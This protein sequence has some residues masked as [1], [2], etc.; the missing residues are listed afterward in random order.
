M[1]HQNLQGILEDIRAR[2]EAF[3]CFHSNRR[4][5]IRSIERHRCKCRCH[6]VIG[7][8]SSVASSYL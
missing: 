7:F 6:T 8:R 1:D 4:M 5:L 2:E 3:E